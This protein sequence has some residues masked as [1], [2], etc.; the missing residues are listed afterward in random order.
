[1]SIMSLAGS[2]I[3]CVATVVISLAAIAFPCPAIAAEEE[4]AG[5][6]STVGVPKDNPVFT[7]M[8]P[9]GW[10][11]ANALSG[12]DPE[13]WSKDNGVNV[14]FKKLG[15]LDEAGTKTKIKGDANSIAMSETNQKVTFEAGAWDTQIAGNK[16]YRIAQTYTSGGTDPYAWEEYAFSLDGK[17]YYGVQF[18]GP[19]QPMKAAADII[20]KMLAS[21]KAK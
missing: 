1:M 19:E 3:F 5:G 14:S 16:A 18:R 20:T 10:R 4:D 11:T 15:E 13:I 21:I 9:E 7:I 12:L 17:T 2:S 6:G 8:M